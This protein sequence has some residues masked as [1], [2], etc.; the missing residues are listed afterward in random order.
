MRALLQFTVRAG[1]YRAL[2]IIEASPA[3]ALLLP[4]VTALRQGIGQATRVARE[5]DEVAEDVAA[6]VAHH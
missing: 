2:E 1:A 6:G 3:H 5:V 4:L